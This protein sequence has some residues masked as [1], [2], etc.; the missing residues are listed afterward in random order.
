M[1]KYLIRFCY[2]VEEPNYDY[3]EN[4]TDFFNYDECSNGYI[5][6]DIRIS[7][8]MKMMEEQDLTYDFIEI[9]EVEELK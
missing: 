7:D 8:V 2:H 9:K 6:D 5:V 3:E 1:K 4:I